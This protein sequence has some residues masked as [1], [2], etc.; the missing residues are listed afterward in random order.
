MQ[1]NDVLEQN[2][3]GWSE[4]LAHSL[5]SLP[6]LEMLATEKGVTERQEIQVADLRHF[7]RSPILRAD[8]AVSLPTLLP[9]RSLQQ[10]LRG[11]STAFVTVENLPCL[12]H[13]RIQVT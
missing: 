10:A 1:L 6:W 9:T 12:D 5:E 3:P 13:L 11:L 4:S 8:K 7:I 2:K